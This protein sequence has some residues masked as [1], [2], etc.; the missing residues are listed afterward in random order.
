M[1]SNDLRS[2]RAA[3]K[4]LLGTLSTPKMM[5]ICHFLPKEPSTG[6]GTGSPSVSV[7]TKPLKAN[8]EPVLQ[9]VEVTIDSRESPK[10]ELFVVHPRSVTARIKDKKCKTKRG[11]SRPPVKRKFS[12]G[13]LTS[14]ATRAK[15][16]SSKDDAF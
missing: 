1:V 5:R 12:L 4:W 2:W 8:E 10:P 16:S 9:L 6:F 13:S 15:T 7:N 11:L 3:R 14:R